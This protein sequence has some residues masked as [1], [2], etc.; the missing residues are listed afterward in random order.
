MAS[1]FIDESGQ[2]SKHQHDQYFVAASFTVGDPRRTEKAFRR[3]QRTKFPKQMRHQPEIKWS[4]ISITDDLRLRTLRSISKMDVRIRYVYLKRHN[5][6]DTFKAGARIQQGHL[7]VHVI[8]ELLESYVPLNEPS[9]LVY[10]D[11]RHLKGIRRTEFKTMLQERLLPVLPAASLFQ[12]DMYDSE[13]HPNIQIADWITGAIAY[14]LEG[15]PKGEAYYEA[16]KNNIL[17]DG[18]EL[19][20]QDWE[21][22]R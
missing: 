3:W 15:K 13:Q 16:I 19:F 8:G 10:C 14:Y 4:G 2:F 21:Q 11:Q 12:A 17:G 18:K 7:Y 5:I 9:M 6:P 20:R 1:I 22:N